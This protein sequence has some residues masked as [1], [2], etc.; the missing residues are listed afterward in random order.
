MYTL[1][2]ALF[3]LHGLQ[4]VTIIGT[5][6]GIIAV[7]FPFSRPIN[8]SHIQVNTNNVHHERNPFSA[9]I[10]FLL[11]SLT[12]KESTKQKMYLPIDKMKTFLEEDFQAAAH[13]L[14]F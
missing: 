12:I 5:V 4:M 3:L 6:I 13:S 7:G 9:N 14:G 10:L 2:V 1:E 11:T 8:V